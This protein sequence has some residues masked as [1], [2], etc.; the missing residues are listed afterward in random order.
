M[1]TPST[2]VTPVMSIIKSIGDGLITSPTCE[3]Y[4]DCVYIQVIVDE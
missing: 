2:P 3:L 1:K 4:F